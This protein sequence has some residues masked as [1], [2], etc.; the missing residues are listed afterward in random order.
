MVIINVGDIA[1]CLLFLYKWFC[2]FLS[3]LN[4]FATQDKSSESA[5]GSEEIRIGDRVTVS[6]EP[7]VFQALQEGHGGWNEMMA[8][9]RHL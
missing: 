9:V 5:S 4:V 3:I 8:K 6:L 2:V 7:D 1:K